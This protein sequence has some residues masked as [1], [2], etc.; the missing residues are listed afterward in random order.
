MCHLYSYKEIVMDKKISKGVKFW[1]L[2]FII[3]SLWT[4]CC[5]ISYYPHKIQTEGMSFFV[6]S[7]LSAIAYLICGIYLLQLN[8]LARKIVICLGIISL[9]AIP[10]LLV[11]KVI[12]VFNQSSQS[13]AYYAKKKKVILEEVKPEFQE[14]A[15]EKLRKTDE[16]GK[17]LLPIIF[18]VF[19]VIPTFILKAFPIYFFTRSKVKEQFQQGNLS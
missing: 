10:I 3:S 18:S 16:T 13:E 8:E 17:K 11:P 12:S 19:F 1:G 4:I 14:Q 15:L 6:F 5:S 2:F 9:V 7:I